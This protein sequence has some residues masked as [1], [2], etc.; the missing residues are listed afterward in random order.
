MLK[1]S[2]AARRKLFHAATT[3]HESSFKIYAKFGDILCS[4]RQ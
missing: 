2:A 4:Y 1:I 3:P